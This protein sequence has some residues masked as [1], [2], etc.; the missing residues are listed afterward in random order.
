M[1]PLFLEHQKLN[2]KTVSFSNWQLPL[3]YDSILK[4]HKHCRMSAAIFD[5][6][7]MGEFIFRGDYKK[8]GIEKAVTVW[9]EKI[10]PGKARYGFILNNRGGIVDDLIVLKIREDELMFVVNAAFCQQDYQ[11]LQSCLKQGCLEDVSSKIAKIDLQGP[12]ARKVLTDSLGLGQELPYFGF[13]QYTYCGSQILISR[14]GYTGELGYEIFVPNQL[15]SLIWQ[16]FLNCSEVKPAGLG[17]RD[18]LRIEMGYSLMGADLNQD[19]T[20]IQAGLGKLINF[21][22]EFIGREALLAQKKTG[23]QS[24]KIAFSA[25]AKKIPRPGD[26][27]FCSGK[28]TGKVTSGTFSFILNKAIGLGY[29]QAEDCCDLEIENQRQERFKV[30]PGQIPFYKQ[31]S[32]RN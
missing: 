22:K 8:S 3:Y 13:S 30:V 6:S 31:G 29:V 27:I 23:T 7:H 10:P 19:I 28:E 16:K 24:R 11:V 18:A 14:T 20:P 17:A 21:E 25:L 4:E 26:K 12:L 2:A 9:I 1:T 32:L 5:V 15:A